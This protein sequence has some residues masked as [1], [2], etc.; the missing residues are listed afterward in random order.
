M[1][2]AI[3]SLTYWMIILNVNCINNSQIYP[4]TTNI[5]KNLE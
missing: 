4:N 3:A 5:I 1:Q 2:R